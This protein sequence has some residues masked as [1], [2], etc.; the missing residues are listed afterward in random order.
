MNTHTALDLANQAFRNLGEQPIASFTDTANPRAL[1]AAQFYTQ[2][3][4]A[5]LGGHFWNF[6]TVRTTLYPY[7]AP[8][9]T[10]TPAATTGTGVSFTA[11]ATGV[12]GFDA[13][14]QGLAG[15]TVSGA[16]TITALVTAVGAAAVTPGTTAGTPGAVN[17]PFT[18]GA[19]SFVAGDLGALLERLDAPGVARLTA[20]GGPT[21]AFGQILTAFE[22]VA[23]ISAGQW[24]LVY[25]DRVL[26]DITGVFADTTPIPAGGWRLTE[27]PPGWGFAYRFRV[28][29]DYMAM[30]R[31]KFSIVYQR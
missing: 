6:A 26:A 29:T 14:G 13:V 30:Q 8:T 9:T 2:V 25:T 10:L 31:T 22:P 17:V 7:T 12:F 16:A 1:L 5:L 27:V 23:P 3:R 15:V 21:Q 24:R 11:G 18:A 4:D 28:P 19:S 20:I